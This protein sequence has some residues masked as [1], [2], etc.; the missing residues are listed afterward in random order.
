MLSFQKIRGFSKDFLRA[1][2]NKLARYGLKIGIN[3]LVNSK[4]AK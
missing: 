4:M 1:G 3:I 2:C